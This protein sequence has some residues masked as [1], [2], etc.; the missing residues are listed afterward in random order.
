MQ[1]INEKY[2]IKDLPEAIRAVLMSSKGRVL[3]MK[4]QGSRGTIW[5]TPGGRREPGETAPKALQR[6]V[7]EETGE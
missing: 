1:S 4:I 6:Q 7:H 2:P 5:I 3:L